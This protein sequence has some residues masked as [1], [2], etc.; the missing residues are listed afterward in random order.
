MT[1]SNDRMDRIEATLDRIA[2][3]Q[4]INTASITRFER[5]ITTLVQAVSLHQQEIET[6]QRNFEVMQGEIKGLQLE[7]RRMLEELRDRREG[8]D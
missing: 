5:A 3:Q 7:N 8:N 6:S 4:E 1:T 2:V